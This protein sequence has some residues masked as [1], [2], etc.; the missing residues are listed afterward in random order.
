MSK[1]YYLAFFASI[2][3]LFAFF[4]QKITFHD[5]HEY[6]T[7]AK[8]LAGIHNVNVFI[9]HSIVYPFFI[10]FF[11]RLWPSATMIALVNV[12]WIFLIGAVILFSLNNTKAFILFAFSPLTWF[13]SIQ[14]TPILPASFFFLLAFIFFKKENIP[15]HIFFSGLFLG[16]ACSLYTPVLLIGFLFV[17]VYFWNKNFKS[18]IGY[19]VTLFFGMLPRFIIDYYYFNMPLYTFI[20]YAGANLIVSLGLNPATDTLHLLSNPEVFLIFFAISPF[21]FKL[22]TIDF[23]V[24]KEELL[25]VGLSFMVLFVRAALLK[26]FLLI[27]PVIFLLLVKVF[28][29]KDMQ[30][31]CILSL[32]FIFFLTANFFM[33]PEEHA[34][35]ND[36]EQIITEHTNSS[37][38][39][40]PSEALTFATYLWKNEPYFIWFEDFEASISHEQVY[41]T[42]TLEFNSKIPLKDSLEIS[43]AFKRF[44]NETYV[45]YIIVS[46]KGSNLSSYYTMM[47]CYTVLC[48]YTYNGTTILEKNK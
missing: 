47:N 12:L 8:Y 24:Y 23:Y 29:K 25:F 27:S 5:S 14:T 4:S 18:I 32:F 17:L 31:H 38:V 48:T 33:A 26:Y 1:K 36:L 30:W 6:I 42:Y 19:A 46:G 15:F 41:R 34:L 44:T 10:S 35:K 9:G 13:V 28:S 22:Y 43:A 11:L 39:G 40:G 45:D 20:R 37:I 3:I 21:L 7:V 2:L 16:I